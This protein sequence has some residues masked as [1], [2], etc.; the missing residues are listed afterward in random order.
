MATQVPAGR[1]EPP[2]VAPVT[3]LARSL[4]PARREP[5][6]RRRAAEVPALAAAAITLAVLVR[7]FVAQAF[8]I[9]SGSML[10]QLQVNDRVVVSK[11]SYRLHPP[12]RGDIV[13]FDAPPPEQQPQVESRNRVV[14]V[15]RTGI[16]AIGLLQTGTEFVK[17]VIALPGETVE[18]RDGHVYIDGRFL[19]EPYLAPSVLTSPFGPVTVAAGH[20]WVMGDNRADSR[21]SRFFGA[22]PTATVVGRTVWRVWPLGHFSFL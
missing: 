3:A 4:P 20:L 8:Y 2:A 19:F 14:R 1:P 12:R 17:R 16:E 11:L 22:I 18:G 5:R 6:G 15:L 21:D 13:V 10:P 9:P 7:L